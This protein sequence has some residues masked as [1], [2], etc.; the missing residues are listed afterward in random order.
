MSIP[1]VELWRPTKIMNIILD[2]INKEIMNNIIETN[3]SKIAINLI[4]FFFFS[5]SSNKSF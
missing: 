5:L 3:I 4:N 2:P 1:W